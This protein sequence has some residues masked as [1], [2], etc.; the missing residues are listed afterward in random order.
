MGKRFLCDDRGM[1]TVD[2]VVIAGFAISLALSVA[3]AVAPGLEKR[4]T[5]MVEPATISTT[6]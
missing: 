4:G 2:W 5:E 1:V 6:F 3:A